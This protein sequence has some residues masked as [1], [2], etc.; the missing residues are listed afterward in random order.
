M[1]QSPIQSRFLISIQRPELW[2][3]TAA[4]IL[5]AIVVIVWLAFEMGLQQAGFHQSE[6]DTEIESLEQRISELLAE[7][8]ELLREN[9]KL[10]LGSSIDKDANDEVKENL[11]DA[12]AK[13]TEMKEELLFYR[14]IVAPTKSKRSVVIKKVQ[15]TPDG[16]NQYKYKVVLIQEGR[17]DVAVRGDVEFSLEGQGS[18]GQVKRLDLPTIATKEMSKRQR[19]GFKYFQNFEGGIRIP[20]G[21]VP[22]SWYVRVLP[23]SSK[24]PKLDESFSWDA[25]VDGGDQGHVGQTE[26]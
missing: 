26:N 4:S 9:S 18:D 19:F 14:N 1:K 25:I 6:S 10:T 8:N 15:L 21:F 20:G 24:V 13:I 12:Q 22:L 17:H 5:L 3:A 2:I 7:K 11:A 16:E 23:K